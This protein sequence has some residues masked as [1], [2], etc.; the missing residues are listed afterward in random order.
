MSTHE[1]DVRP[2]T[3]SRLRQVIAGIRGAAAQYDAGRVQVLLHLVRLWRRYGFRPG[4][5]HQ[6]GL[7][8]PQLTREQLAAAI[9]EAE[10]L[11]VQVRLN[12]RRP[13]GPG[14][15]Q[16]DVRRLLPRRGPAGSGHLRGGG[17]TVGL[18]R[19]RRHPEGR[20]R[21]AVVPR[22]TA[23]RHLRQ[24]GR[25][26]I[27]A[28]RSRL[29]AYRRW[30]QG[31]SVRR[32]RGTGVARAVVDDRSLRPPRDTGAPP[33]PSG[34]RAPHGSRDGPERA[35]QQPG[36]SRRRDRSGGLPVQ[37]RARRACGRQHSR[38][39]HREL[40]GRGAPCGWRAPAADAVPDLRHRTRARGPS[41]QDGFAD[42]GVPPAVVEGDSSP[43][44][45]GLGS[46][47]S[48][49]DLRLG[50]RAH[51][52]RPGAARGEPPLGRKERVGDLDDRRHP[53]PR[54][55]QAGG[56]AEGRS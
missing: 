51:S 45:A 28:R 12:P 10:L 27:R 16:G 50:C 15:G 55:R 9:S 35:H 17:Q 53:G 23:G 26:R 4:E 2:G 38:G 39:A 5:A 19:R 32:G 41:P 42:T 8:N 33:Q 21:V 46:L 34:D 1:S 7:S 14:R 11:R 54:A 29:R 31:R 36:D 56:T 49:S 24:A 43:R 44:A 48:A 18:D 6:V 3:A 52:H 22:A 25:D 40:P 20:R 47:L 30:L 37:A 13:R